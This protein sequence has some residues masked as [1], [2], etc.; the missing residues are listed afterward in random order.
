MT[1]QSPTEKCWHFYEWTHVTG[2][3]NKKM[4]AI[5][6]YYPKVYLRPKSKTVTSTIH[7]NRSPAANSPKRIVLSVNLINRMHF[8][9]EVRSSNTEKCPSERFSR[10]SAS[11]AQKIQKK[12]R[13]D[14]RKEEKELVQRSADGKL[15][16]F[17]SS[18]SEL[19]V[20]SQSLTTPCI[21]SRSKTQ[22]PA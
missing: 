21:Q 13:T 6:T 18:T 5:L 17:S 3:I 19:L 15:G 10:I 12:G 8:I 7:N 4:Q 1:V 14:G 22:L 2:I 11:A 9:W 20:H 16:S